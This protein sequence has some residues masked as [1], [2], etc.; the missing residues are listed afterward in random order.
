VRRLLWGLSLAFVLPACGLISGLGDLELEG[1]DAGADA[2]ADTAVP[3]TSVKDVV[4]PPSDAPSDTPLDTPA[5]CT[6]SGACTQ[7]LPFGWTP[8]AVPGDA[9]DACPNGYSSSDRISQVTAGFGACDCSCTVTKDPACDVGLV[10]RHVSSD[11]TCSLAT[12]SLSVN[13]SGCTPLVNP[14]I[15]ISH[16]KN[17]PLPPSG[18]TCVGNAVQ[19]KSKVTKTTLRTCEN[20]ACAENVCAG[21]VPKGFAACIVKDG[22]EP[23]CPTGFATT[24]TVVGSDFTLACSAC[25]CSLGASTCTGATLAYY[26]DTACSTLVTTGPADGACNLNQSVGSTVSAFKY[27]ATLNRVCSATGTKTPAP[28]LV[29][30]KTV[31][32][33]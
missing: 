21:S 13:G 32:C 12:S 27:A 19:D 18:G 31:C 8:V 17:D 5:G 16:A 26:A 28:T 29:N 7:S 3:D 33:K 20:A 10:A 9:T 2:G 30:T 1:T 23:T 25:T 15:V 24:R 11:S 6:A 4:T 14:T 22:V